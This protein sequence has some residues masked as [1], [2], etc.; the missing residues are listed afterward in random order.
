MARQISRWFMAHSKTVALPR[1]EQ[2]AQAL[3][4]KL[5]TPDWTAEI[6]SGRDDYE[7]RAKALGGWKRWCDDV[8]CCTKYDGQPMYHG[9]I[10]PIDFSA[11]I[12]GKATASLVQGFL[13]HSKHTYSWDGLN[14]FQRILRLDDIGLD[15]WRAWARLILE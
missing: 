5:S 6:V 3:Q 12:V 4:A 1:L 13:D 7:I 11:P 8:P 9:V 14:E 2:W 15:N 10:V